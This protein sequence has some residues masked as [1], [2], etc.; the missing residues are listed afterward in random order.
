MKTR[1]IDPDRFAHLALYDYRKSISPSFPVDIKNLIFFTSQ[2]GEFPISEIKEIDYDG[3]N[4]GLFFLKN[5]K[6]WVILYNKKNSPTRINFSLAHEF[7]HYL[8]HT[9]K[10][11]E[12]KCNISETEFLNPKY[13]ALEME[14]DAFASALL[15]PDLDFLEF[16]KGKKLSNAF[17]TTCAEQF[18]VSLTVVLLKWI[19]LTFLIL[20]R[21]L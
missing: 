11:Q 18:D 1:P 12:F 21:R 20:V 6:S 2:Y 17:F 8:M 14:A 19:K 3:F 4:A 15:I 16:I 7:G 13:K 9:S 10:V 5:K